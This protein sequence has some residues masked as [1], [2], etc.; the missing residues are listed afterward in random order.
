M[1]RG[2]ISNPLSVPDSVLKGNG[3]NITRC[4]YF[5]SDHVR[6]FD[7]VSSHPQ[8][9]VASSVVWT[10]EMF[11]DSNPYISVCSSTVYRIP[12][13]NFPPI[14]S[15]SALSKLP[16]MMPKANVSGT[17]NSKSSLGDSRHQ[18][19]T[20]RDGIPIPIGELVTRRLLFRGRKSN[21]S[22]RAQPTMYCMPISSLSKSCIL[23]EGRCASIVRSAQIQNGKRYRLMQKYPSPTTS[24]I[25]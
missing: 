19:K 23:I 3:F 20:P 4:L 24:K 9:V 14:P 22:S 16:L 18:S 17:K 13:P 12:R 1:V 2:F 25:S 6:I 10:T 21:R 11:R 8:K 15:S 7:R 5:S